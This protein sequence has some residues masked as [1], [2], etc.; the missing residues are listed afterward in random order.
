MY[1]SRGTAMRFLI[2]AL[3]LFI[4]INGK[5]AEFD[6]DENREKVELVEEGNGRIEEE[7]LE[8]NGYEREGLKGHG[9]LFRLFDW[10]RD[11][12]IRISEYH[13]TAEYHKV[14]EMVQEK[15]ATTN[16]NPL[17]R[18]AIITF[19]N[20]YKPPEH[21]KHLFTEEQKE[22]IREHH[23]NR[24]LTKLIAIARGRYDTLRPDIKKQVFDYLSMSS[25]ST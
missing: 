21:V 22:E 16:L 18:K 14:A 2:S 4:E 19:I 10:S 23:K 7:P 13:A 8:G 25:R 20:K 11:E 17:E 1:S 3:L 5:L 24:E 12:L 15:L 9:G 6:G